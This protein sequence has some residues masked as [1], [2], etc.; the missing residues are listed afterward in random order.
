MDKWAYLT[1][2]LSFTTRIFDNISTAH[3]QRKRT[4]MIHD[5]TKSV[6]SPKHMR[7]IDV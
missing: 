7:S 5:L 3:I 2:I 6:F 1:L 4:D